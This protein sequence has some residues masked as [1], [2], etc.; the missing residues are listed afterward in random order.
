MGDGLDGE[1]GLGGGVVHGMGLFFLGARGEEVEAVDLVE[2]GDVAGVALELAVAGLD[3]GEEVAGGDVLAWLDDGLDDVAQGVV[4]E[5][6][7][8]SLAGLGCLAGEVVG[9]D[10]EVE[11]GVAGVHV[12]VVAADVSNG[13]VL[14]HGG[15]REDVARA[16]EQAS[17][18]FARGAGLLAGMV[19]ADEEEGGVGVVDGVADGAVELSR[20][21]HAAVGHEVV[22]V[23]DDDE[24]RLELLDEVLDAAVEPPVV[25]ALS[26]EDVEAEVVEVTVASGVP[27]DLAEDGCGY[28]WAVEGVDP[29]DLAGGE[30]GGAV[31]FGLEDLYGEVL[32]EVVCAAGLLAGEVGDVVLAQVGLAA[33]GDQ[34]LAAEGGEV[35]VAGELACLP[36]LVVALRAGVA[37]VIDF[38]GVFL[39]FK[40]L[41]YNGYE[42]MARNTLTNAKVVNFWAFVKGMWGFSYNGGVEKTQG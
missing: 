20:E 21:A 17:A 9:A 27:R 25:V 32:G 26:A 11:L 34:G 7:G 24:L 22:D 23:V 18:E 35:G 6:R 2:E 4:V 14:A 28:V 13:G 19:V 3:L 36:G 10:G 30:G 12:Q 33:D 39:G 15:Q 29:E 40:L 37:V 5:A 38:H 41:L 1:D 42:P 31:G 16:G 8:G